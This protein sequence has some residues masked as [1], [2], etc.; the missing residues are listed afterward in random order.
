M[1]PDPVTFL[2]DNTME[3]HTIRLSVLPGSTVAECNIDVSRAA[4][5]AL[6]PEIRD[7]LVEAIEE[8]RGR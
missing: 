6:R 5:E 7:A 3:R 8:R 4:L 1:L 2:P